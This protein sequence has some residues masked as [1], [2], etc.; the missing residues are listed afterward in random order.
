MTVKIALKVTLIAICIAPSTSN[1]VSTLPD[2]DLR[3]AAAAKD[4]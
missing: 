1:C 4:T 3:I 2:P